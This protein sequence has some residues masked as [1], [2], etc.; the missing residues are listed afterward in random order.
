MPEMMARV[1]VEDFGTWLG[2]HRSQAEQRRGYGMTDGPIYRDV[3]DP[4]AAFVHIHVEDLARAR[5]W[6]R[7]D[8]FMQATRRA[9][10][11]RRE[12][13]LAE[14]EGVPKLAPGTARGPGRT[15]PAGGMAGS[16]STS[17]P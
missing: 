11:I 15:M 2:N 14:V 9:G 7:T 17:R 1:E 6:F 4:N 8:E 5:Q 16:C 13:Y 10:V 12:F 3:Q